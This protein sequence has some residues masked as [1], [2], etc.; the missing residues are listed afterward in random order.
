MGDG[1]GEETVVVDELAEVL[2]FA[3]A[4]LFGHVDEDGGEGMFGAGAVGREPRLDG[5]GGAVMA[6]GPTG[7]GG[8]YGAAA[9]GVSEG[10]LE[11][12]E[13]GGD[14]DAVHGAGFEAEHIMSSA[15]GGGDLGVGVDGKDSGGAAF[16]EDAELLLGFAAETLFKVEPGVVFDEAAAVGAHFDDEEAG[17]GIGDGGHQE[18]KGG[19][20]RGEME[21]ELA[22]DKSTGEG[23][24]NN[25]ATGKDHGG[26][27]DRDGVEDAERDVQ[28]ESPLESD[29]EAEN[30]GAAGEDLPANGG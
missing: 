16:D 14:G 22:A 17:G 3:F 21:G 11:D 9:G 24:Q 27:R 19:L 8:S 29:E 12:R 20:Q 7:S 28:A 18:A 10:M 4:D 5:E 30:Y 1:T 13:M 6:A 26:N 25:L 2:A 23:Q 15:V